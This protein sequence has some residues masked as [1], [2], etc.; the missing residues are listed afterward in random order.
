MRRGF[1]TP[2][3]VLAL[4]LMLRPALLHGQSLNAS[5]S[6]EVTDPSGAAIPNAQLTLRALATGAVANAATDAGGLYR[7]SNVQEGAYEVSASAK[8]FR[9]FIQ[10]G[11]RV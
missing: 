2:I 11:I 6:G 8:S 1:N 7:F 5:I 4:A 3:A 9:D 10:R